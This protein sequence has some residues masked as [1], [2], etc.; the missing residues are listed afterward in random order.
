M[1]GQCAYYPAYSSRC[2]LSATNG[3][4]C[5]NHAGNR[6][7]VCQQQAFSECNHTGQFVCGARLCRQ[8]E[9]WEDQA[10]PSGAWGFM[11]HSHR[12][13]LACDAVRLDPRGKPI[14]RV[15]AGQ[16]SEPTP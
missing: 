2:G 8:C 16:S 7:C 11:N 14:I 10:K 1:V 13:K 12:R 6:C 3:E 5:E 15:P 9:G 4:F